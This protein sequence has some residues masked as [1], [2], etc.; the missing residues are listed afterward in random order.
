MEVKTFTPFK[1]NG[2][3]TVKVSGNF[4]KPMV[5][6]INED[7]A[8]SYRLVARRDLPTPNAGYYQIAWG[9]MPH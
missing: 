4:N 6:K 7:F 8:L 3:V 5:V 1:K 9:Q 2:V